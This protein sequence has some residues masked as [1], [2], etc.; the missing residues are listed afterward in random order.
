MR[1]KGLQ[2]EASPHLSLSRKSLGN[3][4]LAEKLHPSMQSKKKKETKMFRVKAELS[5][6]AI[7]HYT[8]YG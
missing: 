8:C 4:I 7:T 1:I 5:F 3:Q 2:V 6:R